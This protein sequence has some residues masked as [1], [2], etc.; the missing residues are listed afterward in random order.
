MQFWEGLSRR[1]AVRFEFA[2]VGMGVVVEMA[3]EEVRA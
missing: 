2:G 3:R 1:V